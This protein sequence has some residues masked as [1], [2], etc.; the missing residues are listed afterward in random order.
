[1]QLGT[2]GLNKSAHKVKSVEGIYHPDCCKE[3]K[4]NIDNI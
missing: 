2:S 4:E 1:M 3:S